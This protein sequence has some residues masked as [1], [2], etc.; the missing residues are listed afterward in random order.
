VAARIRDG[1]YQEAKYCFVNLIELQ[2]FMKG[3]MSCNPY[4]ITMFAKNC[5]SLE[6]LFIDVSPTNSFSNN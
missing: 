4:D 3:G 1:I 6:K 5:P 2:L